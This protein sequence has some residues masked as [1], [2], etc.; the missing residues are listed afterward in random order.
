MDVILEKHFR[1]LWK[2][3]RHLETKKSKFLMIFMNEKI[4]MSNLGGNKQVQDLCFILLDSFVT[5]CM[6]LLFL[7]TN[8]HN[9]L[10]L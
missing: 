7:E 1:T 5:S 9:T 4:C 2:G 3:V 6:P 10:T 8:C